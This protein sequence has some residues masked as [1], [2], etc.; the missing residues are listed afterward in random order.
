[1]PNIPSDPSELVQVPLYLARELAIQ[2]AAFFEYHSIAHGYVKHPTVSTES[3]TQSVAVW[4]RMLYKTQKR[5]G[6][7]LVEFSKFDVE[8]YRLT[9]E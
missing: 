4:A 2:Y 6:V 5:V 8:N 7:F 9:D 1:M 3:A